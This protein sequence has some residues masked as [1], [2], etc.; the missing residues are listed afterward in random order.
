EQAPLLAAE[1]AGDG[2]EALVRVVD[3]VAGDAELFDVIDR[4]FAV[5]LLARLVDS[6]QRHAAGKEEHDPQGDHF[7]AAELHDGSPPLTSRRAAADRRWGKQ[8]MPTFAGRRCWTR[9]APIRRTGPRRSPGAESTAPERDCRP[10]AS[11]GPGTCPGCN[12]RTSAPSSN[13]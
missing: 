11:A 9:R 3:G 5:A 12:R 1:L 13:T 7:N 6:R 8:P 10:P 4:R 2:R